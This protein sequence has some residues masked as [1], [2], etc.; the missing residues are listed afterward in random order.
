[1]ASSYWE[2]AALNAAVDLNIFP[3]LSESPLSAAQLSEQLNVDLTR[4]TSL[5]NALVGMELLKRDADAYRLTA[6]ADAYLNPA[7]EEN[8]LGALQFNKDLYALWGSLSDSIKRGEPVIEAQGHLGSDPEQALRF[9]QGMHSRAGIMARGIVEAL[10]LDGVS[11]VLDVA[12]GPA[13]FSVKLLEKYPELRSTVFDLPFIAEAAQKIH[14]ENPVCDRLTFAHGDYNSDALPEGP[15][16]VAFYCGA[17]HQ[18]HPESAREI[19]KKIKT[20]LSHKGRL[21]LVDLFLEDCRTEPLYSAFFD[22]NMQLM[23]PSS[24][25]HSYGPLSELLNELGFSVTRR[26]HI[27][28]TPYGLVEAQV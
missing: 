12:A 10:N 14:Q 7:S 11:S 23:R 17:I 24:H 16:E 27:E 15:F 8:L 26:E 4:L 18:E 3:L 9:V 13:T 22:I 21:I 5:L 25:V 28:F 20:V 19:L 1:M 6:E 2:S